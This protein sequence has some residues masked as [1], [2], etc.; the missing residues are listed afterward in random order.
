MID[1]GLDYTRLHRTDDVYAHVRVWP[2]IILTH[3]D[4]ETAE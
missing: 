2:G 1:R 4:L 3:V